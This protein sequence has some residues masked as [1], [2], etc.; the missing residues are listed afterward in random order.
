MSGSPEQER[1]IAALE[2]QLEEARSKIS[3]LEDQL[4]DAWQQVT[5]LRRDSLLQGQRLH[6][7]DRVLSG[8][9]Y[10]AD[11]LM[12][13]KKNT[14]FLKDPRFQSAYQAAMAT[15]HRIESGNNDG[16]DLHIEWRIAISCWA[17]HHA[18]QLDG[19]FVECG[20]NTGMISSAICRYL[21][22]NTVPKSFYMFDTFEGIPLDQVAIGEQPE[23]KAWMNERWYGD[24]YELAR[25]NFEAFPG[26]QLVRGRVP[27]SLPT[28]AIGQVAYLSIDMNVALPERA[29]L[30]YFWPK[31]VPGGVVVFDDYGFED[32]ELQKAA[33]DEFASAH[34][35]EIFLLPTGQGLL[36]KP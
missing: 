30:E 18:R 19:D 13:T 1:L 23:M 14:A 17:A 36:I 7:F 6:Q 28:V 8:L 29:A 4:I 27:E 16:P 2:H 34:G 20:T 31:M 25:R 9:T 11:G 15:G 35:L 10:S 24:C 3:A 5:D 22:F 21:D 12:T 26:V 33:H 32:H